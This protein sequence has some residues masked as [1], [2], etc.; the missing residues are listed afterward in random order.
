MG[1]TH[2]LDAKE[3][4]RVRGLNPNLDRNLKL[5]K[6]E[7]EIA[8]ELLLELD[9]D[10]MVVNILA[11]SDNISEGAEA[12]RVLPYE[13]VVNEV[14]LLP[15]QTTQ[16][17][18]NGDAE[19][20]REESCFMVGHS[21]A[22]CRRRKPGPPQI[23]VKP[24]HAQPAVPT[25][26]WRCGEKKKNVNQGNN[27]SDVVQA[28]APLD[29]P[30][31]IKG[32]NLSMGKTGMEAR[33]QSMEVLRTSVNSQELPGDYLRAPRYRGP[34]SSRSKG[35]SVQRRTIGAGSNASPEHVH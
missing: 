20:Q 13:Q 17:E 19:A 2:L 24:A 7:W 8:D 23:N 5:A 35:S 29:S 3:Q 27:S 4:L 28:P 31:T 21:Y 14:T 10:G 12:H 9:L 6:F 33:D 30:Q 26:E 16:N 1:Q 18:L 34:G 15:N 32:Q 25:N 22:H 11:N